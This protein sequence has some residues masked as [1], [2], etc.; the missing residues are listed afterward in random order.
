VSTPSVQTSTPTSAPKPTKDIFEDPAIA[1]AAQNDPFTRF[2]VVNWK[3]LAG[4][5]IAMALGMIAYRSVVSTREQK[6]A[7][8]TAQLA[9]VR[10]QYA[11][12]V[13]QQ[14]QI[15]KDKAALV[16]KPDSEKK[17][18]EE[19]VVALEQNL[20]QTRDKAKLML[21]SL[22]SPAPFDMFG[23]LYSGLI[24]ARFGEYEATKA[25]LLAT[26]WEILGRPG[27]SER[28]V[29]ELAAFG[30]SKALTESPSLSAVG[31]DGLKK[32]AERG[33]FAAV[34]A[35]AALAPLASGDEERQQVKGL[36]SAARA[37]IPSQ[38]KVAE[39][40]LELLGGDIAGAK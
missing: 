10:D 1:A 13:K 35:A 8:A 11:A 5:L 17:V 34:I 3:R 30:L 6:R 36:L 37:R 27:S 28:L 33:E 19:A 20:S 15:A 2:V 4:L 18:A 25:A 40:A 29:A 14:E 32:L 24:A 9:Q 21:Q 39:G 16:G 23:R 26:Q 7:A 12:I 22:D 31:K 38:D